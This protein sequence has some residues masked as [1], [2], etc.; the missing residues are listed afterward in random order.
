MESI[1][2]STLKCH[3]FKNFFDNFSCV[4]CIFRALKIN[5]YEV[6]Q[7]KQ[8]FQELLENVSK[9]LEIQSLSTHYNHDWIIRT[10]GNNHYCRICMGILQNID[11][12]ENV[13]KIAAQIKEQDF[14]YQSFKFFIKVP[15]CT[16]IRLANFL[17]HTE[18]LFEK[19]SLQFPAEEQEEFAKQILQWRENYIDIKTVY[20]W[21]LP[22][23]LSEKLGVPATSSVDCP[24]VVNF[25]IRAD[26]DDRLQFSYFSDHLSQ[27]NKQYE[28]KKKKKLKGNFDE[29]IILPRVEPTALNLE[30]ISALPRSQFFKVIRNG[31]LPDPVTSPAQIDVSLSHA[32]IYI[33]GNY[34][35]YSRYMSQTP[36]FIDGVKL[37]DTSIQE[38]IANDILP[39]FKCDDYKFS[40]GG[41]E[42][43]DVRMLG[44]GRPFVIEIQNPRR[45]HSVSDEDLKN[46][47]AH[48]NN[49]KTEC[50]VNSLKFT[51]VKCFE[52][53]KQSE[54]E[55]IKSYACV[56]Q[57]KDPITQE[58]ID[59]LNNMNEIELKQKTPIR[60]LHRRTQMI[61]T[62]YIHKLKAYLLS[63][64]HFVLYVLSSAGT[65]IKE[66]VHGDLERTT[67]N[68]G[69]ILGTEADIFQ[70]D[71]IQL[72]PKLCEESLKDFDETCKV[73]SQIVE[74]Q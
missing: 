10:G 44:N 48:L 57:T 14:E 13:D 23:L 39:N 51:D 73:P 70:L 59:K 30:R 4:R 8:Q 9:K 56:V 25:Q 52:V 65:Y 38:E 28:E 16:Q 64:R 67:P 19:Q 53:L 61:R 24:F 35:K 58:Q 2:K 15:L 6:Y 71:V 54:Q 45:V 49:V 43:I 66:F 29:E 69:S 68:V 47:E 41:R 18:D 50:K 42:D 11:H 27:L 60:V 46:Y 17:Y 31:Q 12:Q 20:K 21:I 5:Q 72:Y 3:I 7:N 74:W 36:W 34:C 33:M 32:S 63:E 22:D 55:K 62:K 1:L 40:T 26:D 37:Y